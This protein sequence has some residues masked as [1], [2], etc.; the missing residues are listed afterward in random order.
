MRRGSSYRRP[1]WSF[2]L[3]VMDSEAEVRRKQ[4]EAM[5]DLSTPCNGFWD[6]ELRGA[7]TDARQALSTPCNGFAL[8]QHGLPRRG[9]STPCNGFLN[10]DLSLGGYP[11]R[12]FQLHVMDSGGA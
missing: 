3:H 5:V 1:C 9:L 8:Y 2:Q 11:L 7:P 6:C 10:L 4:A 12:R